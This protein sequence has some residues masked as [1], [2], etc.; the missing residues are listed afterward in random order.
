MLAGLLDL[1][2][3]APFPNFRS[4]PIGIV[5]KDTKRGSPN[6][7]IILPL[8]L[9]HDN[10]PDDCSTVHYATINQ[11]VK[12]VQRLGVGCFMAK[13]DIKSAF[14]IIPI[15]PQDYSLLGIKWADKYYFDRC[16]PMGCS[17]SFAIFETF[18][19]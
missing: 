4:S 3:N 2:T 9:M 6:S 14:R 8:V 16:L 19:I 13:T 15:H 17:S 1:F 11:A 7:T 5:P 12:I 18:I 10:I